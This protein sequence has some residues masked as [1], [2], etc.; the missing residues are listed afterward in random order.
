MVLGH[1]WVSGKLHPFTV[2]PGGGWTL[3]EETLRPVAAP[4]FS[5]LL[6]NA[7]PSSELHASKDPDGWGNCFSHHEK[8][9][10]RLRGARG[11]ATLVRLVFCT[12]SSVEGSVGTG[13][14]H[15][16]QAQLQVL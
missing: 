16:P 7:S 1:G 10:E 13:H 9:H 11:G 6:G 5:L 8:G 4:G 2:A 14:L 3:A 12:L 15:R